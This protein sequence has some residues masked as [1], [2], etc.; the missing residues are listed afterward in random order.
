MKLGRMIAS[1]ALA[2]GL[3]AGT[4][5]ATELKVSSILAPQGAGADGYNYFA[6][7]VEKESKKNTTIQRLN[8]AE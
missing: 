1:T 3:F 8:G 4:S 2:A 5:V 7:Q 6:E